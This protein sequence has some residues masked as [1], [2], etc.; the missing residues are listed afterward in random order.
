[1]FSQNETNKI[2]FDP[3]GVRVFNMSFSQRRLDF[4]NYNNSNTVQ[5]GQYILGS[6]LVKGVFL[7]D[8]LKMP[9][10]GGTVATMCCKK[11]VQQTLSFKVKNL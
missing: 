6:L 4:I 11:M 8:S 5:K 1:M 10:P 2:N 7:P 9:C 3:T